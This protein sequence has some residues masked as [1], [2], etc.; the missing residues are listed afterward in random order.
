MTFLE[1]YRN[2]GYN[3]VVTNAREIAEHMGIEQVFPETRVRRKKRMFDYECADDSS[4]LSAKEK[5]KSQFFLVLI[6]QAISSVSS[7]FDQLVEWYKLF[8]FLYN[9]N[10]LK[11]CH[12]ENEL[13]NH[14]K[15]FERK[16]GDIDANEL[17]MELNRFIYV[18]EKERGLEIY[19]NLCICIRIL[20]TTPV[21]VAGAE[22]SFSRMK[23]IKNILRSTMTDDRLSALAVISIENK[24]ARSLDYDALINQFAENKARKK[25]FA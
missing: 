13:E 2:I 12:R 21:T 24:I 6:D 15:N 18:I 8:G 10:S 17:I 25:R 22:R 19:P 14:S 20:L 5:F 16:M 1:D 3:S 9:A 23:P 11:Q 4:L 7:R